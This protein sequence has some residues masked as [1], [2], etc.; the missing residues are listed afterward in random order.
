LPLPEG[1]RNNLRLTSVA[2]D[3]S[4][5]ARRPW[6]A[7]GGNQVAPGIELRFAR[8]A[9]SDR[10]GSLVFEY[11]RGDPDSSDVDVEI[12]EPCEFAP[13]T[14]VVRSEAA[15]RSEIEAALVD[16]IRQMRY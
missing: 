4:A 3:S 6:E 9:I 12:H 13:V 16:P 15:Y 11:A 2:A 5:I 14:R 1:I 7:A 8:A 10:T